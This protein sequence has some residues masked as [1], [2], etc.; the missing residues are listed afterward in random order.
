MRQDMNR[1][2]P[3]WETIGGG[4]VQSVMTVVMVS[5]NIRGCDERGTDHREV[6]NARAVHLS[7]VEVAANIVGIAV[8][9]AHLSAIV[10]IRRCTA[11]VHPQGSGMATADDHI[12]LTGIEDEVHLHYMKSETIHW[13]MYG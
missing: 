9:A 10:A 13:L 8:P 12:H 5:L 1:S 6:T 7:P 2:Q 4:M 3:K 11:L